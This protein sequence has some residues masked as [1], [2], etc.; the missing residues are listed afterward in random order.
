[1]WENSFTGMLACWEREQLATFTKVL[2]LN[3]SG[4]NKIYGNHVAVKVIR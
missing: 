3:I 1:M 2:F 4:K